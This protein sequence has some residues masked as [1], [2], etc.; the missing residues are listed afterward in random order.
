MDRRVAFFVLASAVCLVL[1][2]LADPEHRWVAIAT[3]VLYGVLA[4][5]AALDWWSRRGAGD[6]SAG[7]DPRRE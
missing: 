1:T 6:P 5:L 2:P 7:T 4:V 3:A